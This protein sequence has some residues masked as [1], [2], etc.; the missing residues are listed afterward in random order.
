LEALQA[1]CSAFPA[2]FFRW[3]DPDSKPLFQSRQ[4][5]GN[6]IDSQQNKVLPTRNGW[7]HRKA[8]HSYRTVL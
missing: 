1:R 8:H 4:D 5:S 6:P 7:R 2:L 3:L